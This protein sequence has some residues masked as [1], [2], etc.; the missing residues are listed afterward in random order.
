M[1]VSC[2]QQR[3]QHAI[4]FGFDGSEGERIRQWWK[5]GGAN[6]TLTSLSAT[7]GAG[8]ARARNAQHCTFGAM[9]K[10]AEQVTEEPAHFNLVGRLALVQTSKQGEKQPLYYTACAEPK[11][12]GLTCNRRVDESG[13]CASCGRVVKTAVRL[14]IRCRFADFSDSAWLTTFHEAA[15]NVLGMKG[16]DVKVMETEEPSGEG[17]ER[18]EAQIK[19]QYFSE[20][21]QLI[22]RGKLDTYN[23]ETRPNVSCVDARRLDRRQHGRMLLKEIQEMLVA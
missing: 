4:V 18:L 3:T 7:L 21:F 12:R 20:P 1:A 23:G 22:V 5:Q 8:G 15:E 16:E 19:K 11:E 13:F 14:N 9:R 6:Q 10:L 2:L 17:R